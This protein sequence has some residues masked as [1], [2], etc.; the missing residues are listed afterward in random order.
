LLLPSFGLGSCWAGIVQIALDSSPDLVKSLGF[1]D[2]YV[3]VYGIMIGYPRYKF[4][5]IPARNKA[6]ILWK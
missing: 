6:A 5:G 1:P 4:P 3:P 2:E